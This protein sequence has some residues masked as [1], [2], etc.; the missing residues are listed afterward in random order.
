MNYIGIDLG[1]VHLQICEISEA[2][3]IWE[4]RIT[5]ERS[6]II[7]VLRGRAHARVLIEACTESEWVARVVETLGH[8]V[9]VADPNYA[10]MYGRR[11][12][13][14]KT[15]R[16]DALALAEACR[17]GLY[18]PAHRMS[19][20]RRHVR[21]LLSVRETLVRA[22][23][24]WIGVVRSILRRDGLRVRSGGAESFVARV[25]ELPLSDDLRRELRP[26]LACL[27]PLNR[28]LSGLDRQ[29]DRLV[30]QDATAK[31][32]TTV[33]GVGSVTALAF[34][35][36]VDRV[37]RF[38]SPQ[39]V[40]SYLGLVPSEW[41]SSESQ[42]RGHI[43]KMG[44]NR[45]RW[46]LGQAAQSLRRLKGRPDA[47]RLREWAERIAARRNS[48]VAVVALAR[49]LACILFAM[50]RDGTVFNPGHLEPRVVTQAAV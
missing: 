14:I 41:S 26:L 21:G 28:Q 38:Q 47:Q 46:L 23:T 30:A 40:A 48:H 10:P 7:D 42:R 35:A 20:P 11:S 50:W 1:T 45:T 13:R 36:T 44:N 4:K 43:T 31:R 29:L 22:R 32:L 6:R 18:R 15:D 19:E 37:D 33:P 24:R 17:L 5:T 49:R 25:A 39:Q 27:G 16:R 3:E 9:I 12:R 2:G 8:E 34:V